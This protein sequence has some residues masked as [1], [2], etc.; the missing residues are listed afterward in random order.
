[1]KLSVTLALAAMVAF[2]T[3]KPHKH[4]YAHHQ[5]KRDA[6][7]TT[8]ID[9]VTETVNVLTTIWVDPAQANVY[10]SSQPTSL[11]AAPAPQQKEVASVASQAPPAPSAPA[12]APV[13]VNTPASIVPV[14]AAAIPVPSSTPTTVV[15]VQSSTPAAPVPA[16]SSPSVP[17]GDVSGATSQAPA[18]FQQNNVKMLAGNVTTYDGGR[19][20]CGW[21][22]DTKSTDFFALA[23][24]E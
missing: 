13:P 18:S 11:S 22:N 3:A 19:G 1:M 21:T 17:S 8:I 10:T 7:T 14:E 9:D 16:A 20:A 15:P 5:Q 24:G 12:A 2:G 4:A 6:Y 23:Y